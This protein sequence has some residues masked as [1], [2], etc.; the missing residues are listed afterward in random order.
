MFHA[1][2]NCFASDRPNRESQDPKTVPFAAGDSREQLQN[3][4]RTGLNVVYYPPGADTVPILRDIA[5]LLVLRC[6]RRKLILAFHASGLCHRVSSWRRYSFWLFK[7]RPSFIRMPRFKKS[8]L[9]PPDGEFIKARRVY[10]VPNGCLDEFRDS[11]NQGLS[12][13][14]P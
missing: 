2:M 13:S 11:A 8:S 12:I 7:R 14:R 4:A 5:T 9:N 6:F 3:H 10:I 1:R